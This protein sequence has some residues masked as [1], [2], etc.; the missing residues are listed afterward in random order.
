MGTAHPR[1]VEAPDQFL[2]LLKVAEDEPERPGQPVPGL[3][4]DVEL[5]V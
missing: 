3:P 1:P 2:L 4:W 5:S